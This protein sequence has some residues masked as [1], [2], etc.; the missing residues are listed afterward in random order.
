M[1]WKKWA[2][3]H[4]HEELKEGAYLEPALGCLAKESEGGLNR[5]L[6]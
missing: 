3:K 6:S 5:E 1:Y 4:E 2:A